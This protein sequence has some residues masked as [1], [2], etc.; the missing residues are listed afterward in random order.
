[1]RRILFVLGT[2]FL[3]G[4]I[5]G[6]TVSV[7][8]LCRRLAARGFDPLV[9]CLRDPP[10][11]PIAHGA[12]I[13]AYTV[14]RLGDPVAAMVEMIGRLA[15]EAVVVHGPQ[16]AARAA[17]LSAARRERLHVYFSTT[18]YG[19][20]APTAEAAPRFRYAV[21]SPYLATFA[22]A[23]LGLAPALVPPVF[24]TSEYHCRPEGDRILFVNPVANKG[25]HLVEAIARRLPHRR[26]L[27][28]KSWPDQPNFPLVA[29]QRDNV[30]WEESTYDMRPV[31]ARAK[32]VLMPTILEEGWGRTVSEAQISGIPAIVSDRGGLPDTVG[33]GGLVVPLA[34]PVERWSDAIEGLFNDPARHAALSLAAK[35]HAA[36]PELN[37]ENVLDR[38]L[39]FLAS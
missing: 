18:F 31:F 12:P 7:H 34:D 20:P 24:E 10:D 29:F 5:T 6:H 19:Y 8:A 3:P 39:A 21:N 36:R 37:P 13:P 17:E 35:R 1:M 22:R 33:P 4:L 11:A 9:V 25:I 14:L 32:L 38:F 15:P 30:E 16:S 28:V 26:F 23:Y 27:V 2:R